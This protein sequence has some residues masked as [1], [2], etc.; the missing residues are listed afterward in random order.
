MNETITIIEA[1]PRTIAAR[2]AALWHYRAFY[3]LLLKEISMKKFRG[4][5]L[6]FWW[7]VLRPLIPT[8]MAV[9]TFTFVVRMETHG[10]PYAIF[11]FSG[12]ITWY[13]FQSNVM[14]MP[15][16][17]LWMQGMSRRIY[18][19]KLLVPLAS[20]GPSFVELLVT[21]SL[22]GATLLFFLFTTGSTHLRVGWEMLWFLPCLI[23]TL[24]FSVAIGMVTSVIA[25]FFRDVVFTVSYFAQMLFF[26][27]PVIYPVSF[28]PDGYR[29]VLYVLNPMAQLVETSRWSLIGA[30]D[31]QFVFF[32]STCVTIT[33][34]FFLSVAFFLRA[35][36][37][38]ADQM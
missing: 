7:L 35:E 20:V 19:P 37:Y 5:M 22:F 28:I 33:L 11:Y 29:G 2:L 25:L 14:F 24:L 34:A 17:L 21:L 32:A 16:T 9:I 38:L 23:L 3:P 6:G 36:T 4:T 31:F 26:L 18:Y 8:A 12:F 30:G 13:L 1:R 15:R 27:T 10:L